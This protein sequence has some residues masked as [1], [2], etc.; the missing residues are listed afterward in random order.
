MYKYNTKIATGVTAA[1][2][3]MSTSAKSMYCFTRSVH[4]KRGETNKQIFLKLL[5]LH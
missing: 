1:V 2:N 5:T 4:G 3:I